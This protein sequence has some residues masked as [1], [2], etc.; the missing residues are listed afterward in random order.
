MHSLKIGSS[1]KLSDPS[2]DNHLD[3]KVKQLI[4]SHLHSRLSQLVPQR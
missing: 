1:S 2:E 3:N 4:M